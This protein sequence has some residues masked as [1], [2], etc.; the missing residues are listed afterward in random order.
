M[1]IINRSV[2]ALRHKN[3][4]FK[5]ALIWSSAGNRQTVARQRH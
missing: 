3:D 1:F 5:D 4:V 2:S